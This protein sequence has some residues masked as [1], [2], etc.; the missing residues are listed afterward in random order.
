MGTYYLAVCENRKEFLRPLE[1]EGHG[2]KMG[3]F[4]GRE[5]LAGKIVMLAMCEGRWIGESVEMVSDTTDR[6]DTIDASYTSVTRQLI[7]DFNHE[8]TYE[9]AVHKPW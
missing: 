9:K 5:G 1:I 7:D 8:T 4:M 2:A 6:Y 3:A